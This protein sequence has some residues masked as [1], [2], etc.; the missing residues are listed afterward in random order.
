MAVLIEGY[1]VV[2][3]H[4]TIAEKYKGGLMAYK[5]ACL[6]A[7]FCADDYI[8]CIG[9]M[10]WADVNSFIGDLIKRGLAPFKSGACHDVAVIHQSTGLT[11]PCDWLELGRDD[12]GLAIAWQ[13]GTPIGPLAVPEG[14]KYE[15]SLSENTIFVPA[16]QVP[17]TLKF[18]GMEGFVEVYFDESTGKKLY[19]GR[20]DK[21]LG[22]KASTAEE[23]ALSNKYYQ[24]GWKLI[25]KEITLGNDIP[26]NRIGW[27]TL[28]KLRKAIA[29]F[30]QA[31]EIVPTNWASMWTLGKIYQRM[32]DD[33]TALSWFTQAYEI[34]PANPDIAREACRCALNLGR[35]KE[36]VA[37]A[38]SALNADP[39]DPG[40]IANL[41]LALL[42]SGDAQKAK[43]KVEEALNSH[44]AN[45]VTKNILQLINEVISGRKPYPKNL[46]ELERR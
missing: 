45:A 28:R 1:S 30:E 34:K 31:L 37:F 39:A 38:L 16:G 19:V 5:R 44:P 27:F 43:E 42:I 2:V 26:S 21:D 25:E 20:T 29:L 15:G 17:K 18:I 33:P 11:M 32:N 4:A 14:W 3:R 8:S 10:A 35:R 41:A 40:L 7:T 36:A 24:A 12:R 9:F 13:S 23:I 6:N 46:R 22:K